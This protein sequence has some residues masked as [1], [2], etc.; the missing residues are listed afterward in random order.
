MGFTVAGDPGVPILPLLLGS[1]S[2][3]MSFFQRLLDE[4]IYAMAIR[5]PTVRRG[6]CRIRFTLSAAHDELHVDTALAAL[7]RVAEELGAGFVESAPAEA[8][9]PGP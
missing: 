6:R 7:G 2:R 9:R 5:P 1:A 3:A 4:G 8:S